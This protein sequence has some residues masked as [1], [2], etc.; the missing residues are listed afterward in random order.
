MRDAW[1]LCLRSL[2]STQRLL[3]YASHVLD[4]CVLTAHAWG[5]HKSRPEHCYAMALSPPPLDAHFPLLQLCAMSGKL[6]QSVRDVSSSQYHLPTELSCLQID[7][8]TND[9]LR[10]LNMVN[11]PG[12]KMVPVSLSLAFCLMFNAA[13]PLHCVLFIVVRAGL[14]RMH[15]VRLSWPSRSL[16]AQFCLWS[17]LVHSSFDASNV[18]SRAAHELRFLLDKSD[19]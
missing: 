11:L 10:S 9:L 16:S 5:K 17:V 13:V 4:V 19:Q 12:V 3:K 2:L 1:T 15:L 7:Q 18:K 8:D 6:L 14:T